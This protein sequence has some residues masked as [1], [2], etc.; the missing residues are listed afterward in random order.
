MENQ[1]LDLIE[2][3]AGNED[4]L[5]DVGGLFEPDNGEDELENDRPENGNDREGRN[6][7]EPED[8]PQA[9]LMELLDFGDNEEDPVERELTA[10]RIKSIR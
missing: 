1:D 5:M 10:G 8:E 6:M 3:N 4:E 2:L 9:D 7:P